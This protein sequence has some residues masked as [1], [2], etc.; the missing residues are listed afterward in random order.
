MRNESCHVVQQY[1]TNNKDLAKKTDM[2]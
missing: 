1:S 2:Y